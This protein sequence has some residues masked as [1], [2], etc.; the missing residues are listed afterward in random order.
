MLPHYSTSKRRGQRNRRVVGEQDLGDVSLAA[1]GWYGGIG[2]QEEDFARLS[3]TQLPCRLLEI[4]VSLRIGDL[5]AH[6]RIHGLLQGYLFTHAMQV[7]AKLSQPDNL[8]RGGD[9]QVTGKYR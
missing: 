6:A 8:Y 3:Q 4:L 1:K 9:Q 7:P 5:I 2:K